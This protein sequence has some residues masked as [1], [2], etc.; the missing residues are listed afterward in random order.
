[1]G[2]HDLGFRGLRDYLRRGIRTGLAY[3]EI[4]LRCCHTQDRLWLREAVVN[5]LWGAGVVLALAA[6]ITGP[7][8]LCVITLIAVALV[9][10][11]KFAQAL[12][13]GHP[14]SVALI[15][16]IHTYLIKLP[17][18]LG[19]CTWLVRRLLGA[20]RPTSAA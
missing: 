2:T 9:T 18:F 8:W 7:M 11:R 19:E 6:I 20:R 12:L 3:A 16:A 10:A 4:A 14:V 15:Y 17:I 5:V 13:W 1:M